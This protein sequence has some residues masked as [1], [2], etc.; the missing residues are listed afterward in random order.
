MPNGVNKISILKWFAIFL[1]IIFVIVNEFLI[2]DITLVSG[3]DKKTMWLAMN[4]NINKIFGQKISMNV[5]D[6]ILSRGVPDGYGMEMNVSFDKIPESMEAMLKYDQSE[7]GNGQI[8][9]SDDKFKRYINIGKQIACE[10]CC[11]AKTLVFDDGKAACGCKHSQAMRG[12]SAYLIEK[13]GGEYSDEQILRELAKWKG[14]YFPSA[15]VGK[16][17]KEISAGQYSPDVNALLVGIDTE[18]LKKSIKDAPTSP[19]NNNSQP[20]PGQQ[21]GC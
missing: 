12:L 7:Y 16:V 6:I 19:S 8:K 13:H 21:G 3:S 9:L 10:F 11:G 4:A 14:V 17:S 18:K 5:V 20:L 2:S 1:I 15:M